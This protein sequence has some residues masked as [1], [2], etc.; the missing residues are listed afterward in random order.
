MKWLKDLLKTKGIEITDEALAD[1]QKEIPKYFMP[2][3]EYNSK[4]EEI[5]GLSAQIT[6]RDKQLETLKNGADGNEALKNQIKELQKSNKTAK[7]QFEKEINGLKFNGALELALSKTGAK[8]TKALKGLLD[9]DKISYE[10]DNLIGFNEQIETIKAENAFLFDDSRASAMKH[11]AP[12]ASEFSID[13][14]FFKINPDLK[15]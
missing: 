8:N 15:Q 5:K 13:E 4:L 11:G 12:P 7:E 9:M 14:A 2:K 10:N 6:E 3:S 1:V